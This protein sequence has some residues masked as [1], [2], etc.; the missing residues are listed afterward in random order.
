VNQFF[1]K[2]NKNRVVTLE[3]NYVNNL[4][5][6]FDNKEELEINI[7][8]L[9]KVIQKLKPDEIT[10]IELRYF[11]ERPFKEVGDILGITETNAKVKVHR[12]IQKMKDLFNELNRDK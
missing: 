3:D 11:E 12:L 1:R 6:E 8:M 4:K 7:A 2:S 9:G 10:L 5:Y